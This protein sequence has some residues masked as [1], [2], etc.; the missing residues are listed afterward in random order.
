MSRGGFNTANT[1][2]LMLKLYICDNTD[3]SMAEPLHFL[4]DCMLFT[5]ADQCNVCDYGGLDAPKMIKWFA[6]TSHAVMLE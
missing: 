3:F 2:P 5:C 6:L 4:G 1:L